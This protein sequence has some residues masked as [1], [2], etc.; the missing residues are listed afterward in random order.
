[1]VEDRWQLFRLVGTPLLLSG[2]LIFVVY[3]A[4]CTSTHPVSASTA[5]QAGLASYQSEQSPICRLGVGA[6]GNIEDYDTAPLRLGWYVNWQASP[7]PPRPNGIQYMPNIRLQQV[8]SY[9]YTYT[10]SGSELQQ[11]INDNPAA[12]WLIGNEPDRK[13]WQDD[14]EPHVYAQAYHE[15]YYLVKASDPTARIFAGGIVQPTEIRLQYLDMVLDSYQS[16]YGERLPADGWNIHNFIL[17]EVSCDYDPDHCWGADV[18]PG[19]D[20]PY[21][22]ILT[23]E[24]NDNF[25]IFKQRIIRFRQWMADRGYRGLPVYLSEYGVQMPPDYGFPP[26]RVNA[27]M[28]KTLEYMLTSTD[29]LLGDPTDGYRLIQRWAWWSLTDTSTN[30]WLFD[31]ITHNRT[32]FGD[33]WVSY[34]A[35]VSPTIDLYPAHIFVDPPA[36][37]SQG[38]NVTFTLK[39]LI[40]NSGNISSTLPITV[41][42]YNGNPS[43]GGTLIGSAQVISPLT[44]CGGSQ[45]SQVEWSDVPTGT[46]T[47]FVSVDPDQMIS[48]MNEFNN[49]GERMILVATHQTFLPAVSTD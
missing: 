35:Q 28:T 39:A 33:Q 7:L 41:H 29:P 5:D 4:L 20:E 43:E 46:H 49:L 14:L 22:E 23:I 3:I 31:P 19:V 6:S 2:I 30:G 36:P 12:D 32:T 38:G 18:P 26:T 13:Q 8:G 34:A 1:M 25:E 47:V 45:I 48:E 44:G 27:Y 37:F 9:S 10:P 16:L 24:D 17:N 15:L 21:G 42:F 11:V 40:A